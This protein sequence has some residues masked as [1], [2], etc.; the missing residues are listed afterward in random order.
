MLLMA[1]RTSLSE[2]DLTEEAMRAS[3]SG[4]VNEGWF[5]QHP[6]K[7]KTSKTGTKNIRFMIITPCHIVFL[8]VASIQ[9]KVPR[10]IINW[11][12]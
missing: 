8:L 9:K 11:S 5:N 10:I 7:R 4:P 3:S 1:A 12:D 2:N 6:E